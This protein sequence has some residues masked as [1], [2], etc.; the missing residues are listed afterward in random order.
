MSINPS[1]NPGRGHGTTR[2][3]AVP[4]IAVLGDLM[5]TWV[6]FSL[7]YWL[8]FYS[9]LTKWFPVTLGIPEASTILFAALIGSLFLVTLL[10][11]RG[12]YRFVPGHGFR[13]DYIRMIKQVGVAWI[14]L[15]A[16]NF[17][18]RDTT[19]SRMMYTVLLI[20]WMLCITIARWIEFR[21]KRVLHN[22]SL[23]M[24]RTVL[25]G[26]GDAA[27]LLIERL[28]HLH[29]NG[30]QFLG[31]ISD[32]NDDK[33]PEQLRIGDLDHLEDLL[34]E[35]HIERVVVAVP[36]TDLE[37]LDKVIERL[38]GR[39]IEV[40]YVPVKL[41]KLTSRLEA[42]DIEG[43]PILE[44]KG[45]PLKG[46][47]A[48]LKRSFDIAMSGLALIVLSPLLTLLA[49]LV[50][51]SSTGPVLYGQDRVTLHGR[52]FKCWKYRSMVQ[53]AEKKSGA[54]WAVKGDPRVTP[55]G[56]FLRRSSLDELPQLWNIFVGDLSIVGPRPERPVFVEQFAKEVPRY[57]DR[58]RVR[59]GLTGWAQVTGLRGQVP[60]AVRTQ[61]DI[62]YVENW[63]FGL[64]LKII[65]M[66]FYAVIWG[67][68]AY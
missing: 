66:T 13:D 56:K 4:A 8:R 43:V 47:N 2:L 19:W 51:L 42:R 41:S 61:A 22:R 55:I 58:H 7:A 30:I 34:T 63:T 1:D 54:V 53:D 68:D 32:A 25:V 31:W 67:E 28:K 10:A 35:F 29:L 20:S 24:L 44:L 6:A 50:K 64:D 18:Y 60:I 38:T 36:D 3:F 46:W 14:L 48:V 57:N 37:R 26:H 5:G 17:F 23:G 65:L 39:N 16:A 49:I 45:V 59:A 9:P 40:A 52:I 27:Q 11:L 33:M 62:N 21:I 15:I 12:F